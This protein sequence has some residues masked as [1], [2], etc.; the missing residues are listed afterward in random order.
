MSRIV[1]KSLGCLVVLAGL[2]LPQA[3]QGQGIFD[4]FRDQ[5]RGEIE[6]AINGQQR[7]A[8]RPVQPS[9][10]PRALGV[11]GIPGEGGSQNNPGRFEP[12]LGGFLPDDRYVPPQRSIQPNPT[13]TYYP[14]QNRIPANPPSTSSRYSEPPERSVNNKSI[15]VSCPS[16]E[17]SSVKYQLLSGNQAYPFT[18]SPGESQS[19]VESAVWLIRF[20]N[21]GQTVTYRLR[22]G[23]NFAFETEA[24][25]VLKLYREPAGRPEPPRRR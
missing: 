4:G 1:L 5:L 19:F 6:Q 9:E 21:S 11:G 24:D 20:S 14:P 13:Q 7:G 15:T 16:S 2:S 3:A 22:G 10:P 23:N 18:M 8:P 12:G 25:G 17:L